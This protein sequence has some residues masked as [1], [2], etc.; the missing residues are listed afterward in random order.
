MSE[1]MA[2]TRVMLASHHRDGEAFAELMK[3]TYQRRFDEAFWQ[4]WQQ[5]MAP[6]MGECSLTLDLGTGPGLFLQ[7][8]SQRYPGHRA[9]GV[10]CAEYMLAAVD[11]GCEVI[12]ADLHDPH[13]PFTNGEVDLVMA[14]VVLHEMHQPI[15]TLQEMH[16]CLKS[17]GRICIFDWV[18]VPL[19]QYLASEEKA[20]FDPAMPLEE[21]EGSF[22]H[23]IEHNRFSA[24]D[25]A[26]MLQQCGFKIL[27]QQLMRDGQFARLIAERV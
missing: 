7:E 25:L 12:E 16:R 21:L 27:D 22:I 20:V 13:L 18:R 4:A 15:R 6:L 14:S 1:K 23:F 3:E 5:W 19:S 10:E 9:V 17:G 2:Q 26:F 24:D 8:L 11:A